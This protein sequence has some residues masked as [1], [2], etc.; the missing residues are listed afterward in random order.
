MRTRRPGI[1]MRQTLMAGVLAALPWIAAPAEASVFFEFRQ[2]SVEPTPYPVQATGWIAISDA[3]YAA[4]LSFSYNNFDPPLLSWQTLGIEGLYFF[5]TG[6]PYSDLMV[7]LDMLIAS[8][9]P[10]FDPT[11]MRYWTFNVMST[12]SGTPD[13]MLRYFDDHNEFTWTLSESDA[14]VVYLSDFV[15]DVS[16][17]TVIHGNFVRVPEPAT[18]GLLLVGLGALYGA[19]RRRKRL[20]SRG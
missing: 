14:T 12:P 8:S 4:G 11:E 19:G 5:A 15:G 18:A 16:N 6:I 13:V 20:L 10:P 2:T 3:A 17:A 9:E 1:S 7:T